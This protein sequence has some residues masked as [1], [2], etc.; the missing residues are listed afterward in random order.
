M[1]YGEIIL[2]VAVILGFVMAYTHFSWFRVGTYILLLLVAIGIFFKF[3]VRKYN[4]NERAII[5]RMGKFNRIAGPGWAIV[6]PFFEKEFAKVDIRTK[7]LSV[8]IPV[9]FTKDDLRLKLNGVVYYKIVDPNKALLKIDNYMQGLMDLI[10]AQIRNLIA[11]MTMRE[12]F[13]SL[14][15]LNDMLADAIRHATWKWGIDVPMVQLRSVMPPEEIAIAMQQKEVASQFMQAE[16]FR[17]EARK[18]AIEALGDAAKKLDDRALMYLY[19]KAIEDISKSSGTKLVF[20]A[21]FM[22]VMKGGFGV[23]TGLRAAGIDVND[24]VKAIKE[25]LTSG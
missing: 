22:D 13:G 4:Q 5:F 19:I 9:A 17:A 7:M 20:P 10:T 14:P 1:V 11:S 16:K 2:A 12:V 21:Q 24:A 25:K 23:G 3:F 6:I 18:L 15:K 8:N